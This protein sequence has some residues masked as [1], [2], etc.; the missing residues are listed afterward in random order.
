MSDRLAASLGG[1]PLPLMPGIVSQT[2]TP[3]RALCVTYVMRQA[4]PLTGCCSV[5]IGIYQGDGE[6]VVMTSG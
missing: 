6:R 5:K 3:S 1:L 2:N 4:A